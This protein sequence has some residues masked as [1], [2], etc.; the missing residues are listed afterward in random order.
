MVFVQI[1]CGAAVA[2]QKVPVATIGT[3]L[4]DATGAAFTIKRK[5]SL[6]KKAME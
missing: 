6:D 2:G 1:V 3:V 5:N 4:Y